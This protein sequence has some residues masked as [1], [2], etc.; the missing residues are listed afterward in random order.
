MNEIHSG[1][2][3]VKRKITTVNV[4]SLVEGLVKDGVL[5]LYWNMAME[6]QNLLFSLIKLVKMQA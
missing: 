2:Y 4:C 5:F 3:H 1:T 6:C